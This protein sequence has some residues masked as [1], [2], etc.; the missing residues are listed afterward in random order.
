M[1]R[2]RI[3]LLALVA[4]GGLACSTSRDGSPASSPRADEGGN[5]LWGTWVG[6]DTGSTGI[7]LLVL[8]SDFTYHEED[9]VNCIQAPCPPEVK[10]FRYS[11]E[12]PRGPVPLSLLLLG[13]NDEKRFQFAYQFDEQGLLVLINMDSDTRV[14]PLH[15][16]RGD[17]AWCA[18]PSDCDLQNLERIEC[19]GLWVCNASACNFTCETPPH[20][21]GAGSPCGGDRPPGSPGCAD[22]LYCEFGDF[23]GCGFADAPGVCAHIPIECQRDWNPVCGCDM[24]TYANACAAHKAGWS[25]FA[26]GECGGGQGGGDEGG[27]W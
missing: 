22:G 4:A 8:K 10:E 18:Q 1:K 25:L 21:M 12:L 15:F 23:Q 6:V 27:G 5:E 7:G 2:N 26:P 14:R 9:V 13:P 19:A 11:I 24:Q 17:S 3:T 16:K 20:M